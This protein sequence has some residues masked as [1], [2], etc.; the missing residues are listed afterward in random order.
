MAEDEEEDGHEK[1]AKGHGDGRG[2]AEEV[3]VD[4]TQDDGDGEKDHDDVSVA[5]RADGAFFLL[6]IGALHGRRGDEG[7]IVGDGLRIGRGVGGG[8][9]AQVGDG[10]SG[11]EEKDDTRLVGG[12]HG[13]DGAGAISPAMG[14]T[15]KGT[16][17]TG[18][19]QVCMDRYL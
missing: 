13:A 7:C 18:D 14:A 19:C 12:C 1:G 6:G 17:A 8:R 5:E 2:E 16:V 4:N 3:E 15:A 9:R 10:G 11:G